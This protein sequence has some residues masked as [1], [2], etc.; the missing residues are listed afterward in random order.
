MSLDIAKLENIKENRSHIKARC[1]ACA[2]QGHDSKGNHLSI[3]EQ[4]RFTCVLYSGESGKGHRKRI[5]ELIGVNRPMSKSIKVRV[6]QYK[7][8]QNKADSGNTNLIRLVR[9]NHTRKGSKVIEKD[10]FGTLGTLFYNPY[11]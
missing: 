10:I 5:F 6:P 2:E 11:T 4:G 7:L 1:P 3:D 9:V 8:N